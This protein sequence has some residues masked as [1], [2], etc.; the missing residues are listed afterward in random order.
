MKNPLKKLIKSVTKKK[1]KSKKRKFVNKEIKKENKEIIDRELLEKLREAGYKG[2]FGDENIKQQTEEITIA[3][4]V[5]RRGKKKVKEAILEE[6]K[7]QQLIQPSIQQIAVPIPSVI[8]PQKAVEEVVKEQTPA[9]QKQSEE[10][11]KVENKQEIK[12]NSN[13]QAYRTVK[14]SENV[15]SSSSVG[16]LY[17]E[18]KKIIDLKKKKILDQ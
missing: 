5:K 2:P 17:A 13:E 6:Q 16:I 9:K 11:S 18:P 3:K 8:E 14:T 15:S 7:L 12:L 4:K 10:I 1:T